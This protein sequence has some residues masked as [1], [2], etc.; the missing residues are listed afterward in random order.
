MRRCLLLF[1]TCLLTACSSGGILPGEEAVPPVVCAPAD[2]VCR[3]DAVLVCADDGTGWL[4]EEC[5]EGDSCR[6]G[7]C[8]PP[9]LYVDSEVLPSGVVEADYEAELFA[10]GGEPPYSWY[11]GVGEVPEGLEIEAVGVVSGVPLLPGDN[12]FEVV[13]EDMAGAVARRDFSLTVHPEP[14]TILTPPDLGAFDEGIELEIFLDAVGGVPPYGWFVL[15][16]SLPAGLSVDAAGRIV[17]IPTEAGEFSFLL[18]V[19]DA[20]EPPGWGEQEF[21]FGIEL[22]PLEIIGENVLDIFGFQVVTLPLLTI[23]PGI[24]L[25]YSTQLQ[26]T[27]GLVPYDWNE[28]DLPTLLQPL[29]PQAGVPDGL[30]LLADGLLTGSVTDTSQVVTLEIPFTSISLT[31]FFFMADVADSQNPADT[32]EALFLIPTLPIG[33]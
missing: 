17:G 23:V 12:V 22:R 16:G 7:E 31:G 29:L 2:R 27:G 10:S 30:T 1:V 25:P 5:A 11:A 3:D 24:P 20:Q 21:G 32:D 33:G 18:R 13:V 19:V 9:E 28:Q 6:D 8:A 15:D 14:V 4:V 26:A